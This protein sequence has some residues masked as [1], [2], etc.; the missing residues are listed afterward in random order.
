LDEVDPATGLKKGK[1]EPL[2]AN[3]FPVDYRFNY[4]LRGVQGT[5]V[6][7]H[8]WY[9]VIITIPSI[10]AYTAAEIA[11]QKTEGG[12]DLIIQANEVKVQIP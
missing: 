8:Y 1:W 7:L 12:Q 10:R 11:N 5:K 9:D 4:Y 6:K 2:P 3:R